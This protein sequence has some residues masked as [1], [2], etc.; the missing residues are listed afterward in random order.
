M[1]YMDDDQ[2]CKKYGVSRIYTW[3]QRKD[4]L[5]PYTL[6]ARRIRYSADDIETWLANCKRATEARKKKTHKANQYRLG[7]RRVA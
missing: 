6:I 7:G 3:K 4:G 5:L 1:L 2:F